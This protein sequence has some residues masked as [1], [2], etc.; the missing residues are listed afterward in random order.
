MRR[1]VQLILLCE[2]RQQEA[3]ARRFLKRA[4][5]SKR[6]VRVDPL[7]QGRGAAEKRVREQFPAELSLYRSRC[8][9][10]QQ[11]LIVMLDGDNRGVKGRLAQLAEACES[12]GIAPRADDERVAIFVPTWNIEAWLAYLDGESVDE[13]SDDYPRLDHQRDCQGHVN[14]LHQMCQQ[15]VLRQPSPPSL[16]AACAEYRAR[17]G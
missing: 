5:W 2:D 7:A 14:R 4:G 9:H 17:L 12:K 6:Q 8:H 15:R 3:F 1:N 16:D 10:L 11:A 13:N